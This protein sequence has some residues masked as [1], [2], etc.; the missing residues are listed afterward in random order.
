MRENHSRGQNGKDTQTADSSEGIP[1]W[2][3]RAVQI[4]NAIRTPTPKEE[5]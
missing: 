3:R 1:D 2:I 4:R 5:L